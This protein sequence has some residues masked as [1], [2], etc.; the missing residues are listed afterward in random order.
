MGYQLN[1]LVFAEAQ[2]IILTILI[3]GEQANGPQKFSTLN[4]HS[5]NVRK[6]RSHVFTP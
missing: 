5:S 2:V 6:I 4:G 3:Q 1:I